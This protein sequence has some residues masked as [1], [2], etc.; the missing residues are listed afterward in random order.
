MLNRFVHGSFA[1]L[2]QQTNI[3]ESE[4]Q[5]FEYF[6]HSGGISDRADVYGIRVCVCAC[7]GE[8]N[9]E[10]AIIV[11][12]IWELIGS[13]SNAKQRRSFWKFLKSFA[14]MAGQRLPQHRT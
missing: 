7:E 8:P 3:R 2:N 12:E 5:V 6:G 11:D 1:S 13:K 14:V 9:E 4:Y 10:K